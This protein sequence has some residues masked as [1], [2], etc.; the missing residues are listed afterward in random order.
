MVC[1]HFRN[2]HIAENYWKTFLATNQC[3]IFISTWE[4]HGHRNQ[5]EWISTQQ[6]KIEFE[7][8]LKCLKPKDYLIEDI[9]EKNDGF[10]LRN[11]NNSLWFLVQNGTVNSFDFSTYIVSQLYKIKTCF[12]LV[13]NYANKNNKK[14]DLIFKIRADTFPENFYLS[15]YEDIKQHLEKDVLF[16]YNHKNHRHFGGG[17]GCASCQI[18]YHSGIKKHLHHTNDICDY[19]NYG[20]FKVMKKLSEIFDH[21]DEIYK[22]MELHNL[23]VYRP[24]DKNVAYH[25][26]TNKYFVSWGM[27]IERKYKCIYPEK[28]IREHL[29]DNWILNDHFTSHI[30]KNF[31]TKSFNLRRPQALVNKYKNIYDLENHKLKFL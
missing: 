10:T 7:N 13:E 31:D 22:R 15:R 18:E 9:Q 20:N 25:A 6:S 28:F 5:N 1:G 2:F 17:G 29:T 14:Y 8:I 24:E 4:D 21:K 3:D 30:H 11:G 16:A 19:F 27:H 12:D 26:D 23:S